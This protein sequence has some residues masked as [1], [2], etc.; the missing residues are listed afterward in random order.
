MSTGRV[1][2]I[3]PEKAS[4]QFLA[5][6][7]RNVDYEVFTASSGK[8]GL[9]LAWKERPHVLIIDPNLPDIS[10]EEMIQKLR[11]DRRTARRLFIAFSDLSDPQEVQDTLNLG[12]DHYLTKGAEAVPALLDVIAG[13]ETKIPEKPVPEEKVEERPKKPAKR[14]KGKLIV[15]YS[16][17]GGTGTSSMCANL[18]PFIVNNQPDARL[19]VVDMV[20]PIGSISHIVGYK[21]PL[22][23]IEAA[24]MSDVDVSDDYLQTSLPETGLWKFQLLAGSPNPKDAS[25]LNISRIPVL[26]NLL[27]QDFDFVMVDLGRSLSKIS[28]PILLAAD[29]ICMILSPEQGTVTLTQIVLEY[30]ESKG[31]LKDQVYPLI[32]RAVGLE[33]LTRSEIEEKLGMQITGSI[34]YM[35]HNFSLANNL[36]LPIY[37][38]FPDEVATLSLRQAAQEIAE[39]AIRF[40]EKRMLAV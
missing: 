9:I 8:E 24:E 15:L 2:I 17:K 18:A 30:L 13:K 35:G 20:L 27:Q 36:H 31:L 21:G 16:A 6:E 19:A 40:K 12:Y 25:N 3:D 1:L 5:S 7:I 11:G 29:Q 38:K 22:N 23:I 34:P 4:L 39:R 33:G 37:Y 32:N 26:L 28:L 10:R 14:S